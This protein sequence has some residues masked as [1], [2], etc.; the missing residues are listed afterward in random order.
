MREIKELSLMGQREKPMP[1]NP[2]RHLDPDEPPPV[3]PRLARI[4][5]RRNRIAECYREH[6][7]IGS[8]LGIVWADSELYAS[9]AR[10]QYQEFVILALA[11]L[12]F[13]NGNRFHR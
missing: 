2:P 3:P 9:T 12:W 1:G 11:I 6:N 7:I 4:W 13:L 5:R 10:P 8:E